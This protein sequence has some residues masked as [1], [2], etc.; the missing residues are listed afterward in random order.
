MHCV[1]WVI[2]LQNARVTCDTVEMERLC[3]DNTF[4]CSTPNS[5]LRTRNSHAFKYI[6]PNVS[7]DVFKFSFFLEQ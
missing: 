1:A 6:M 4:F 7:K 5:E 2:C 3:D